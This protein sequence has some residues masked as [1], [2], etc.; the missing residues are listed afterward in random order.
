MEILGAE[1]TDDVLTFDPEKHVHS[2]N[3]TYMSGVS[4]ILKRAGLV[5][6]S[7]IPA[8]VL[9]RARDFGTAVHLGCELLDKGTLDFK[10]LDP[11]LVPYIEAWIKFK[12]DYGVEIIE[13]EQA[14]YSK[15]WWY[16]GTPDR[17]IRCKRFGT[18][19]GKV[20]T[21]PDIKSSS[22]I[23]PSMRLQTA[24]YAIAREEMTKEKIVQRCAVQLLK[25]GT[26]KL[27][28]FLDEADRSCWIGAVQVSKFKRKEKS[29]YERD[30]YTAN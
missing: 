7:G 3:G 29:Y 18:G 26:Y 9:E 23:Y 10:S 21:L 17:I 1:M 24:A 13:I 12:E 4:G 11:A 5:D 8:Q 20:L 2:L 22:T 19:S 30:Q 28:P 14:V 6:L 16:A 15:T 25:D 27:H